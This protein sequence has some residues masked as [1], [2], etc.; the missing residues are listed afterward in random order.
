VAWL[1]A[2]GTAQILKV[3]VGLV[4]R[5]VANSSCYRVII[6]F[7]YNGVERRS[8]AIDSL[9]TASSSDQGFPGVTTNLY[10]GMW[11]ATFAWHVEDMDLFNLITSISMAPS[12]GTQYHMEDLLL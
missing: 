10:F 8:F 12:S 2:R 9:S 7:Y 4:I 1:N 6:H 5:V 3:S 11:R